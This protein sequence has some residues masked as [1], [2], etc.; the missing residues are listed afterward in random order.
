VNEILLCSHNPILIKSLYGVLRDEGYQ[1]DIADHP[2]GAVQLIFR[3]QYTA[4][5][6]D[7]E[8]FGL[9]VKDAVQI[10]RTVQPGVIVIFIGSDKLGIDVLN[11][12]VPVDL[13]EF[14]KMIRDVPCL[15]RT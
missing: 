10:M 6:M 7:P 15:N 8:P 3:N 1:I 12:D 5:I 9:P 2:A 11:V 13:E 14:K 4:V